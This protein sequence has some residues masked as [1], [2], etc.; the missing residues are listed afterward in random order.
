[1]SHRQ[2]NIGAEHKVAVNVRVVDA[3]EE[4]R[5]EFNLGILNV[6]IPKEV[7]LD[8]TSLDAPVIFSHTAILSACRL[9]AR[10]AW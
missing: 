4:T 2:G 9:P 7:E 6:V 1:M 5:A 8:S 10:P 3:Q